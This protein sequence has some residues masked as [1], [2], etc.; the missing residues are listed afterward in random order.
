M[1]LAVF[2]S[3]IV[4]AVANAG[5]LAPIRL[6]LEYMPSPLLGLDVTTPR[7]GWQLEHTERAQGQSAFE[8]AV[9]AMLSGQTVWH[10][11]TTS[12]QSQQVV[13]AGA[14]LVSDT[15]YTWAVR[16]ADLN[17]EVSPWSGNFSFTTGLLA[18]SDWQ[19]A[20]W[21]GESGTGASAGNLLRK[22]FSIPAGSTVTQAYAYINGLGYYKLDVD[23]VRVS[24]HELGTFTTFSQRIYYDTYNIVPAL[25][26]NSSTHAIGIWLGHGWYAQPSVNVGPPSLYFC[27]I[28]HLQNQDG[29]QSSFGVVSDN[30]WLQQVGPVVMDD[31][32]NG[33]TFDSR[34]V[35]QGWTTPGFVAS[36]WVNTSSVNPPS[37][38][39]LISSHAIM[40][41]ILIG[42][43]YTPINMWESAPGTWVFD[44]GQN[45][46]GFTTLFVPEGL[47][48][49]AGVS[50][51]QQA[52]EA[53]YGPPPAGI[54]HYYTNTPEITTY[55]TD[56]SGNAITYRPYFTYMG[57]RYIQLTGYPGV[58]TYETLTAHFIHTDYEIIGSVGFS[59]PI[60]DQVQHMTQSSAMSNF[61]EIP[62]DCPQRERRGW[63]GDAQL[64]AHTNIYNFDMAA[65]YTSFIQQINDAQDPQTGADQ[66]CVPWYGHGGEPAD[67]AWGC[68][69]TFLI[70]DMYK[71]YGDTTIVAEHY[72]GL[73]FYVDFLTTDC[74]YNQSYF[75]T[76]TIYGDWC[77]PTGGCQVGSGMLSAF[78]IITEYQMM[79]E[80]AQ[81]LGN[82]ADASY[83]AS[84][85]ESVSSQFNSHWYNAT[86][87]IYFDNHVIG[88]PQLSTQSAIAFAMTLGLVPETDYDQ[89]LE[90]LVNDIMVTNGGHLST[91]IV[92]IRYLLPALSN[93]G[94]SDIALQ[95]AQT[96]TFPGW[97]YMA[98]QGATTVWETW[99]GSEYQQDAS[100]NHIMFGSNSAW[101]YE[102][103]A[104]IR[105][106]E[107]FVAFQNISVAPQVVCS[108]LTSVS[109]S[110]LSHRGAI[111]SSWQC[112]A[113]GCSYVPEH[114]N[115]SIN[116]MSGVIEAITF[117]SF[118]TPFGTCA[119]G[120]VANPSCDASTTLAIVEGLCL[121]QAS[122]SVYA[123][124]TVFGDPCYGIVKSLAI[125]GVCSQT[126]Y[127]HNVTVPVGSVSVVQFPS[128]DGTAGEVYESGTLIWDGQTYYPGVAGISF[129]FFANDTV[130]VGTGSGSYA[131]LLS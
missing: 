96:R 126:T 83:F 1:I 108:N 13:Y 20:Q 93:A 39:V 77:P 36:G 94:R 14:A 123:S 66:D 6:R 5:P 58:P 95:I 45:M 49:E 23:G 92:G 53:I 98:L 107:G 118:G 127:A 65:P 27:L 115:A 79:S 2:V 131:F 28:V 81:V 55:I 38:T 85:A 33:E 41:H 42:Q 101:Y 87:K 8:I 57:Q 84:L 86:S 88:N 40:P 67:P 9:T 34:L 78:V 54:N 46:A 76:S 44:F 30:T 4:L 31:I 129:A 117:A 128:L 106:A 50:I 73:K 114:A 43:S 26:S 74:N 82:T 59:D 16:Y 35:Q 62:T 111:E 69:Y 32:Y 18:P 17:G 10:V 116:C 3:A 99:Y 12:S 125:Q 29:T 70:Y 48:T 103:L 68:A 25:W 105:N 90:N 80:L 19:N 7:F 24:T 121:G 72:A 119:E 15:S 37:S 122:C 109:A 11:N 112:N 47:A 71:Y 91:G 56:G 124:D 21:I 100:W 60:L 113:G 110:V 130:F 52:S 63:L 89:V 120:F 61:Q 102:H 75:C 64:S 51:V 104:G 97:G 22:E